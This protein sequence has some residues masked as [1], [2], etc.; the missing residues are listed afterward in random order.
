MRAF[1]GGQLDCLPVF[2]EPLDF[3]ELFQEPLESLTNNQVVK[4]T[5]FFGISG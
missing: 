3:K 4:R 5:H 1:S 2:Q